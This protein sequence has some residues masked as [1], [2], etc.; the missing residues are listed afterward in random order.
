VPGRLAHSTSVWV[1]AITRSV[2]CNASV[3]AGL[4]IGTVWT[5]AGKEPA[6]GGSANHTCSLPG[7][8]CSRS[9]RARGLSEY[10]P[11]K[12]L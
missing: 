7:R 6:C 5:P 2:S 4:P 3:A 11:W 10:L 1:F 12:L 9:K 8:C